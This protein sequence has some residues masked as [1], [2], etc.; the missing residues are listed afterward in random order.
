[1][2]ASAIMPE[3]AAIRRHY[4]GTTFS[5]G[6]N[7]KVCIIGAGAIGGFLGA[8]LALADACDV[9]GLGIRVSADIRTQAEQSWRSV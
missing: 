9:R 1:M 7:M 5:S 2:A 3:A 8:R 6:I 4:R